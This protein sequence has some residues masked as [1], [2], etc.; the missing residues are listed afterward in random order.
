MKRKRSGAP[1]RG[2]S[3]TNS[4]E[5]EISGPLLVAKRSTERAA[6]PRGFASR[7]YEAVIDT[8]V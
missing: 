6:N 5:V 2:Q 1:A 3:L 8:F 4:D 7:R